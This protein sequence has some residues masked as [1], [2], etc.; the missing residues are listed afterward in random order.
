MTSNITFYTEDGQGNICDD[1]GREAMSVDESPS[2]RLS[3][4]KTLQKLIKHTPVDI[5][6][7]LQDNTD[8]IMKD[9]AAV[10]INSRRTKYTNILVS[11]GR[12]MSILCLKKN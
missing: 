7:L 4:L 3:K 1:S 2:F 11:N 8:V 9:V 10:E 12:C 6:R 5:S